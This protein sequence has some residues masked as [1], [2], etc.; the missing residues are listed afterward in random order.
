M[1][2]ALTK[3]QFIAKANKVHGNKFDYGKVYYENNK[4]KVAIICKIH[5]EFWQMPMDHLNTHGCPSCGSNLKTRAQFI[6]DAN[7]IHGNMARHHFYTFFS[8]KC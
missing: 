4:T 1:V 8:L 5:G 6:E 3:K 7:K 2:R